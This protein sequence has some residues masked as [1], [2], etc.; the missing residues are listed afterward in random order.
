[1]RIT[2]QQVQFWIMTNV[3]SRTCA[4]HY[5]R[6]DLC[7]DDNLFRI[8]NSCTSAQVLLC[9]TDMRCRWQKR[10]LQIKTPTWCYIIL[11]LIYT[12]CVRFVLK[13]LFVCKK[14]KIINSV[15]LKNI[16]IICIHGWIIANTKFSSSRLMGRK[17]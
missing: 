9:F 15:W 10:A 3:I 1:M 4:A 8:T 17:N 12:R 11:C 14:G 2:C 5:I 6:I 16:S 13:M 7:R